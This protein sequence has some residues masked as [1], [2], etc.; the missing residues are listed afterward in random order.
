VKVL[1]GHLHAPVTLSLE[2]KSPWY[3]LDRLGGPRTG[4]DIVQCTENQPKL[5]KTRLQANVPGS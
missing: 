5:K 2:K 3:A 4:L 1:S